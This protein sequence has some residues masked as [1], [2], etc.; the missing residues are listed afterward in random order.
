MRYN[1]NRIKLPLI[2][3]LNNG[4]QQF[5]YFIEKNRKRIQKNLQKPMHSFHKN[6]YYNNVKNEDSEKLRSKLRANQQR[7]SIGRYIKLSLGWSWNH[8]KF[9]ACEK[10]NPHRYSYIALNNMYCN[11]DIE[12][13]NSFKISNGRFARRRTIMA[14]LS[15]NQSNRW[16]SKVHK[17]GAN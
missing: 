8:S 11:A 2:C 4:Y 12:E 6:D 10:H 3:P 14:Q 1:A 7:S 13:I 16:I 17:F 15:T 9:R 5:S